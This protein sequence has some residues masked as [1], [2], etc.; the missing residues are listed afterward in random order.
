LRTPGLAM[1][2]LSPLN[3]FDVL[4][5]ALPS[6]NMFPPLLDSFFDPQSFAQAVILLALT[7]LESSQQIV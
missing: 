1:L 7:N 5:N 4:E 6:R 2:E 3:L